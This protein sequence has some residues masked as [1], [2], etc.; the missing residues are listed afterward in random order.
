MAGTVIAAAPATEL[1]TKRR[2][3][4]DDM[5]R[6]LKDEGGRKNGVRSIGHEHYA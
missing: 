2:R 1:A 5:G 6:L 3:E 4:I